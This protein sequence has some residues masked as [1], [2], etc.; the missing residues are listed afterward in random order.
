MGERNLMAQLADGQRVP[1]PVTQSAPGPAIQEHSNGTSGLLWT[2]LATTLYELRQP[3]HFIDHAVGVIDPYAPPPSLY[4]KNDDG[5]AV[6]CPRLTPGSVFARSEQVI[7]HCRWQNVKIAIVSISRE[8]MERALPEPFAKSPIELRPTQAAPPDPVLAHL[9]GAMGEEVGKGFASGLLFFESLGNSLALYSATHFGIRAPRTQ[10]YREGL[11]RERRARVIEYISDHLNAGL[12]IRE[13]AGVANL[14][15]FH[16]SKMF[17]RS[18]GETVHRYVLRR[19]LEYAQRLLREG[20][21]ELVEVALAVGFSGQSQFTAAFRRHY[22]IT[23][24]GY[25]QAR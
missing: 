1:I 24:G 22:G 3:A 5:K 6:V 15:S 13:L 21:M 17:Q 2:S 8:F 23:P 16:F 12:S 4:W 7:T 20:Q 9:I 18:M 14:S 10:L 19:R 25:R 11:S